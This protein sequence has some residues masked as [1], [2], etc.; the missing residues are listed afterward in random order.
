MLQD[1][2]STWCASWFQAFFPIKFNGQSAN[3]IK[4]DCQFFL[5]LSATAKSMNFPGRKSLLSCTVHDPSEF[6]HS[7]S[8]YREQCW[9]CFQHLNSAVKLL[10]KSVPYLAQKRFE[11]GLGIEFAK[12]TEHRAGTF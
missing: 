9:L 7:C 1:V 10:L 3:F 5:Y 4:V 11:F 12:G 6:P 2:F 8:V